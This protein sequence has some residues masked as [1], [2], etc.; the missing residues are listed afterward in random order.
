MRAQLIQDEPCP[1]CGS[2]EHPFVT[3]NPLAHAML[4]TLEEAYNAALKYHNTLSGDITSLEQ[5]CKKLRLDSETFGKSLQE[6]TTQIAMLEEKW[7]GFSLATASAAVSDENRAQWLE[8]QVQQLQ[9]AQRE[10]AEQL[11]AYETKR[12]AAEVLKKQLDTKLQALSANKE[13][14]KDRQREKT[15]KEEAQERIARQLEHITQTLQTMTEQ[16]APHFSNPDWVDNWKKDPQGFNDKIVAFARQWKQQAEAIIANNQQL[17]EH[18]SALQEMS[19]QG[20]H[21][22]CIKRKDQCP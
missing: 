2:K 7:T 16:L 17:R 20:R 4:K 21:C 15:S 13:Q 6:R 1:V 5:F 22:C 11:N 19:K 3:D 8:Q 18:Q 9:A 10:V 14:L 12:Q